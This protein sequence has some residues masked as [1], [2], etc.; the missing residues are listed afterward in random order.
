MPKIGEVYFG[1]YTFKDGGFSPKLIVV[2]HADK[3]SNRV[4]TCIVTKVAKDKNKT[5]GCHF[6]TQRFLIL[7]SDKYFEV[8][9][10]LELLRFKEWKYDEFAP[11][12]KFCLPDSI[13]AQIK[14]CLKKL[15][16][17]IPPEFAIVTGEII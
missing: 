6:K 16:A 13:I 2:L 15:V 8:N 10:S 4:I 12:I 17:D 3:I 5:A 7:K 1:N 11:S 14:A 9:S